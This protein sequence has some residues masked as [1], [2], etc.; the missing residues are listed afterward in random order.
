MAVSI[1]DPSTYAVEATRWAL[2]QNTKLRDRVI[3][4]ALANRIRLSTEEHRWIAVGSVRELAA[5]TDNG[6]YQ[7]NRSLERLARRN[8]IE[9]CIG[10][11]EIQDVLLKLYGSPPNQ[12]DPDD[13][14]MAWGFKV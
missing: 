8:L 5:M 11:E 9:I 7:T 4:A 14:T 1:V 2:H 6:I 10:F 12:Q 3:L 13:W